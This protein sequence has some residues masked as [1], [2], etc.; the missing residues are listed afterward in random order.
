L[1]LLKQI[2][3]IIAF[4]YLK[5]FLKGIYDSPLI[6]GESEKKIEESGFYKQ[7]RIYYSYEFVI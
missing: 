2:A 4:F 7:I 6:F 5:R 1:F 3:I